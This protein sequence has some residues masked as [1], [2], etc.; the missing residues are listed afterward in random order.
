[1]SSK[2]R[3]RHRSCESKTAYATRDEAVHNAGKLRW[4]NQGGT[5]RAY[6]CAFCG[7]WHVGRPNRREREATAARRDG[8]L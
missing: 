3:L 4:W 7:K 8:A 5:W 6:R 2:R 1:M